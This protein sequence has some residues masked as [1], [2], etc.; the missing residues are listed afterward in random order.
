[1]NFYREPIMS[2]WEKSV[3]PSGAEL[4][5]GP[6]PGNPR[7]LPSGDLDPSAFS[8][9]L[10]HY[11]HL[12]LRI[13]NCRTDT[14]MSDQVYEGEIIELTPEETENPMGGYGKTSEL[15]PYT[16]LQLRSSDPPSP[17]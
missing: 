6:P 4:G 5:E 10:T 15:P 17:T 3:N 7:K 11:S 12:L 13:G 1:M 9:C 2:T 14:R 8:V 16:Y